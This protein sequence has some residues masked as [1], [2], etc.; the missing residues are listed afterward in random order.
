MTAL[1]RAYAVYRRNDVGERTVCWRVREAVGSR[2]GGD[3]RAWG[4]PRRKGLAW[5]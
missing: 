2:E 1:R 4:R 5:G 3:I